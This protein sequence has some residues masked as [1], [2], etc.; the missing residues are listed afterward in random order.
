MMHKCDS[1]LHYSVGIQMNNLFH[2]TFQETGPIERY[3]LYTNILWAMDK[4]EVFCVEGAQNLNIGLMGF[5]GFYE[6]SA[7][8]SMQFLLRSS[9][10]HMTVEHIM[11]HALAGNLWSQLQIQS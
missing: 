7:Y 5:K 10:I 11:G 4:Y 1:V 9:S 8:E 3:Y 2:Q 6:H